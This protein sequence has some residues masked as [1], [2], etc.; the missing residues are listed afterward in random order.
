M[1]AIFSF[2]ILLSLVFMCTGFASGQG[3]WTNQNADPTVPT[4]VAAIP[5]DSV[6]YF[7]GGNRA[8]YK[9]NPETNL[10]TT[11]ASHP[12]VNNFAL[13]PGH[14]TFHK[15]G[16][17]YVGSAS[18]FSFY[19]YNTFTNTWNS[20][21]TPGFSSSSEVVFAQS[22]N[23][24]YAFAYGTS[25][26][27]RYTIE[28][29]TWSM[30]TYSGPL[31]NTSSHVIRSLPDGF[32]CW[33]HNFQSRYHY[34]EPGTMTV[35]TYFDTSPFVMPNA[36]SV[37]PWA[38]YNDRLFATT[39]TAVP[40]LFGGINILDVETRTAGIP[41][42]LN[43]RDLFVWNEE[44]YAITANNIFKFTPACTATVTPTFIA[45]DLAPEGA[46]MVLDF[47]VTV[48]GA[49]SSTFS[50]GL[51][52]DGQLEDTEPGNFGAYNYQMPGAPVV[53][54]F[55]ATS[56][57]CNL[58]FTDTIAL[59]ASIDGGW[60]QTTL[61]PPDAPPRG[62]AVAVALD[63]GVLAGLGR[64]WDDALNVFGDLY[65]ME[66]SSRRITRLPDFPGSARRLP[67][68][69]GWNNKAFIIGG[70]DQSGAALNDG[71]MYDAETGDW[72]ALPSVPQA[73]AN[74]VQFIIGDVAYVGLGTCPDF[75]ALDLNA[76][77]WS[78]V[79]DFP[80]A[81]RMGAVGFTAN[82]MGY[83]GLGKQGSSNLSTFFRF[84]PALQSFTLLG[85]PAGLVAGMSNVGAFNMGE[86]VLIG[87]GKDNNTQ[88]GAILLDPVAFRAYPG[89]PADHSLDLKPSYCSRNGKCYMLFGEESNLYRTGI[90]NSDLVSAGSESALLMS[91]LT[92]PYASFGKVVSEWSPGHCTNSGMVG[93]PLISTPQG[94][95]VGI[96][97]LEKS[98]LFVPDTSLYFSVNNQDYLTTEEAWPDIYVD[99]PGEVEW[100]SIRKGIGCADTLRYYY[101]AICTP[102]AEESTAL[103]FN[104]GI[105][106]FVQSAQ[107]GSD[108]YMGLG[109]QAITGST[110]QWWKL[111]LESDEWT[112]L[113]PLPG[114]FRTHAS[115]FVIGDLIYVAGGYNGQWP[116]LNDLWEYNT[117]TDQWTQ[118]ANLPVSGIFGAF[119][120]S[121]GGK[122]YL[123]GGKVN[124]S[125]YNFN[126]LEYNPDSNTWSS[127]LVNN[128]G[129]R[130]L[131]N[132]AVVTGNGIEIIGGSSDFSPYSHR[133]VPNPWTIQ[134]REL[135][136]NVTSPAYGISELSNAPT[137]AL[138]NE[139]GAF[140]N[141]LFCFRNNDLFVAQQDS[142]VWRRVLP[143]DQMLPD[144]DLITYG[145]EGAFQWDSDLIAVVRA[146][147][148]DPNPQH[149]MRILR[150][151][152]EQAGC[153]LATNYSC[154]AD[155]N[156]DGI[157]TVNDIMLCIAGYQCPECD[158]DV[159]GNGIVDINDLMIVLQV[160]GEMC[161]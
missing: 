85:T 156:Q 37:L 56:F 53:L 83:V 26:L 43:I 147:G 109:F 104:G 127:L 97:L 46:D 27:R 152:L 5:T 94:L 160:F 78:P 154:L 141:R 49:S 32:E 75:Y 65:K 72:T 138:L 24:F 102:S 79:I 66:Y 58:I 117:Q 25:G 89:H 69:F 124:T 45:P 4:Q 30:I 9:W 3:T 10:Y 61:F 122:G 139:S 36:V 126:L 112:A 15:D 68:Y 64:A 28:T 128:S 23:F 130:F 103:P 38:L 143:L 142:L 137:Y 67:C 8:L 63:D 7:I 22:E 41:A 93:L 145:V 2:V 84:D 14:Y 77:T 20:L 34:Q 131:Y 81:T 150:I 80:A 153:A 31:L 71:W 159:D 116:Y 50:F 21:A 17:L 44:L 91:D 29:N 136:L 95:P 105:Q 158:A 113:S 111:N 108:A 129:T 16:Y 132:N 121:Y 106:R 101:E 70:Y 157:V 144:L 13:Q 92:N 107:I 86:Y 48:S 100:M 151:P 51:Y 54:Q 12:N 42:G 96:Q 60:A 110:N 148:L 88:F 87:Y 39:T 40:S 76:L 146:Q 125:A 1:R 161:D 62:E 115:T 155:L 6:I 57:W 82:G 149:V 11:L 59:P 55:T 120:F 47:S 134:R 99:Q 33:T 90:F 114:A 133:L 73:L 135:N 35:Q 52:A 119:A 123:G 19:R 118:R 98:L 140:S 18:G 74:G